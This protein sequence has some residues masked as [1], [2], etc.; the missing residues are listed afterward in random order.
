[1]PKAR[2]FGGVPGRCV[3]EKPDQVAV[4]FGVI[5]GRRK[6]LGVGA[7]MPSYAAFSV[8]WGDA[9]KEW[10]CIRCQTFPPR[11]VNGVGVVK[12]GERLTFR[13]FLPRGVSMLAKSEN[14]SAVG[15]FRR[16]A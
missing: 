14:V 13:H 12:C 3:E 15:H 1:M 7:A 11:S 16:G 5:K 8:V 10:S 9:C 4:F 2:R 6:F